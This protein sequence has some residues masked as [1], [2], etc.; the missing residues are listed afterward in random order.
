MNTPSSLHYTQEHEWVRLREDGETVVIGITD[1]AQ[2]E[3]G[4]IVFVE[5]EPEGDELDREA[6]FGSVEAV[7]AVSELFMPVSGTITAHN[8]TL[9]SNPELV[10]AD[11]YGEGWM[12]EVALRDPSELDKLLSPEAYE[13]MTA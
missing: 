11:P 2:R 4:D 13:A 7:K 6:V 12:I 5:L 3:L 9:E 1:Y 8:L 10:N